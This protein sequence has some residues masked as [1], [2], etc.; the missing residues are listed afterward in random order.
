MN[1]YR[2]ETT[3]GHNGTLTLNNLPFFQGETVEVIIL[4]RP[5]NTPVV[6]AYPLRG[7]P[8]LEYIDP[9]E[10]VAQDDWEVNQ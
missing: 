2:I 6:N 7:M 8:I 3:L 1:A 4:P 10:P 5:M 9:F